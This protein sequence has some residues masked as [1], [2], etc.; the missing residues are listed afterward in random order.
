[1]VLLH[2]ITIFMDFT[3]RMLACFFAILLLA[4]IPLQ[5]VADSMEAN[6]NSHIDHCTEELSDT[7]RTKGY[8]DT[9]TYETFVE[10][11][12]YTGELYDIEIEDIHPVTGEELVLREGQ[13]T[14]NMVS[15][16]NLKVSNGENE[17]QSFAA[18]THTQD[19]YNGHI[20]NPDTS[21]IDS[22]YVII[23]GSTSQSY[24]YMQSNNA[25]WIFELYNT[26]QNLVVFGIKIKC[27][28]CQQQAGYIFNI[29]NQVPK[30]VESRMYGLFYS[31]PAWENTPAYAAQKEYLTIIWNSINSGESYDS[32]IRKM[33]FYFGFV[34]NALCSYC[35]SNFYTG[36]S[37]RVQYSG[38]TKV[39]FCNQAEGT[40]MCDKVVTSI[41]PT[42]PVQTVRA[43]DSMIT[44]ATA[45]YL[46]G[47]TSI[48]NCTS[49]FNPIQNGLQTVTLTYSGLVGN[50]KT[51]GNRT[52][53]MS[54][55]VV[56]KTLSYITASP[57]SQTIRKN[58]NPVYTVKANYSD[59]SSAD[60]A[61]SLYSESTIDKTTVGQKTLT[62]SYTEGSITKST[63]ITVFVDDI[64][65][66]AASPS[67]LTVVKYT[68]AAMIPISII[69]S[70]Q[71]SGTR[72]ITSG[73]TI[74]G[75]NSAATGDQTIIINYHENDGVW[76]TTAKVHVT[77]LHKT[78]LKCGTVYDRNPDDTDPGCPIC[79]GTVI[80]IRVVPEDIEIIQGDSLPIIVQALYQDG[81]THAITGW[82]SNY[83]PNIVGLQSVNVEYGEYTATVNVNVKETEITCPICGISYPVSEESCPV[84]RE[85]VVRLTVAPE[86]VTVN[87]YETIGLTVIANYADGSMREV[88]DWSID[89]TTTTAGTYTA[90]VAY[91][92]CTYPIKLTVLSAAMITC[93]ICGLSYEGDEYPS[94]CPVCSKALIGIEAYLTS[95][96]NLVQY[97]STPD[98]SVVLIFRDT[99]R[100]LTYIGYSIN[101][102]D[103]YQMG[104]QTVTILYKEI[105]YSFEIEVVDTLKTVTCPNG[106]VYYLNEDGSDPGCPYC[107]IAESHEVVYYYNITYTYEILE[108]LYKNGSYIF[109]K[110]NYINISV[111]KEDI[112]ILKKL[113]KFSVKAVL[114]SRKKKFMYGGE[115]F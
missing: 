111:T 14:I 52:C 69:I 104:I 88:E 20:H 63:S 26:P 32:I 33:R 49:N 115:V 55:T 19:C 25:Q 48:V 91:S 10:K 68:D 94:G 97:G 8:L 45:T 13:E 98:L 7:I 39:L 89:C 29:M 102:Y 15:Q 11:L 34:P 9:D 77:P 110:R 27:P 23:P 31:D 81:T 107:V 83:V 12:D 76:N 87:Q 85:K 58:G 74:T 67:D 109:D 101:G 4:L 50:A 105:S 112:S 62:I 113:Q 71:Y 79:R 54:V 96:S 64:I 44:T 84:C 37:T 72:V 93:Q 82:T 41:S 40:L 65:S 6:I 114:L 56:N 95:G 38:G 24:N 43:G 47:H 106:H 42:N 70:Y 100:E 28:R 61:P 16:S 103:P 92:G 53:T 108:E 66:I 60:I 59:G 78:C 36:T 57:A 22:C 2:T 17:I 1:M 86:E 90:N 46:D 73:F 3:G 21:F 30:T 80:G 75:Y 18:H 51:T 35:S 5:Y 99:H